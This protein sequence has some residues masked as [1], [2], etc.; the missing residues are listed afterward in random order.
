[1]LIEFLVNN[2]KREVDRLR[3]FGSNDRFH[4]EH[5]WY[6]R[7]PWATF[8][9]I[10]KFFAKTWENSESIGYF[11]TIND[12]IFKNKENWVNKEVNRWREEGSKR[13]NGINER[14]DETFHWSSPSF[15]QSIIGTSSKQR[16]EWKI[17]IK[18]TKRYRIKIKN[19]LI[20]T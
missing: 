17:I 16:K 1:M 10:V 6:H 5:Q 15:K 20:T 3:F 9:S 19:P 14:K 7:M 11:E 13:L 2:F 12:I 18:I 8:P 4:L